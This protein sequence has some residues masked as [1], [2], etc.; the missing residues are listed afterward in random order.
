MKRNIFKTAVLSLAVVAM[1]FSTFEA[2]AVRAYPGVIKRTQPDGK[3]ISVRLYGDER[4]NFMTDE[5]GVIL[6][7]NQDGFIE[8]AVKDSSGMPALSGITAR[9]AVKSSGLNYY[10]MEEYLPVFQKNVAKSSKGGN[11]K[12]LNTR[13]TGDAK[14]TYSSCAFPSKGE[15]HSIVVL[16]EYQNVKFSMEDPHTYY[17]N[18]LNGENFTQF[19][20]TGSC[21]K[22]FEDN[23]RGQFKVTFDLYGPI[24]LK[25][26]RKYYGGG[27]NDTYAHEMV[28]EAV[29]A[30]D[31]IVDFSQYDHNGDRLVDSIYIIYAGEG[32]A[33]GGPKESVWPHSWELSEA[34]QAK[35]VDGV[36]V[37]A[38]GCSN[39]L[40]GSTPEGIGGFTHEF[41]HVMG[42]PDLYNT[43]N[44]YDYTTPCSWDLLDGGSYNN[45]GRTPPNLSAFE[46]Y[47]LGWMKP[48]EIIEDGDYS[49]EPL[50]V[51][52]K[53]YMMTT[54]E[55]EDEFFVVENRQ[56]KGWDQF[57]PGH[58]MLVWHIDFDQKR[59]DD[60]IVNN[61]RNHQNVILVR[62]DN[63]ADLQTATGDPFPGLYKVTEFGYKST[64][65]L[66]SWKGREL[67]VNRIFDIEEVQDIIRFKAEM[68][69]DY[70]KPDNSGVGSVENMASNI[71]SEGGV[72]YAD[73]SYPVYDIAGRI[74]GTVSASNPLALPKGI[75][76]VSGKKIAVR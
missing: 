26:D 50:D 22:Y 76:I 12:K 69:S 63:M 44:S 47:S 28:I 3:T 23:S 6:L 70:V 10:M 24:T 25:H 73:G 75:Y 56:Q 74:M 65:S 30:L 41:C 53:A 68:A 2:D 8:Y 49:L 59:W 40:Y 35:K 5:N 72:L 37:D 67:N 60:N 32:E 42:L 13:A 55:K 11:R 29:D 43:D 20:A 66:I 15:P 31:E 19:G 51:S 27:P 21:S 1:A 71:W 57:L 9:D 46:L 33:N 38:Y 7:E 34:D 61:Q 14:Y 62:A 36:Y 18:Y 64:P 58:G 17:N 4:G 39:E 45:E 48:E 54:R 52:Y 16:V